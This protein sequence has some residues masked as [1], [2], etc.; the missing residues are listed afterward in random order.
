MSSL[1]FFLLANAIFSMLCGISL[2]G[3]HKT[4][5]KWFGRSK[6]TPFWVLG[7]G[8]VIFSISVFIQVSRPEAVGVFYII[9]QD[10]IWVL[11]SAGILIFKPF[12]ITGKGYKYITLVALI[13]L[14]FGL[15][16]LW[17]LA[18]IDEGHTKGSKQLVY[19]RVV[20]A[21][22]QETWSVVSNV[23][24]YHL[25]APNIDRVEI[26]SGYGEGMVRKCS[27]SAQS[28]TETATLWKEGEAYAFTVDTSAKDY[29]FPFKSLKGT[30]K[31]RS[32]AENQTKIIMIF[33][34]TYSKWIYNLMVHPFL[35]KQF[36]EVCEELLN[37]WENELID[38]S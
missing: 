1:Q 33:D 38:R 21:S 10:F 5:A 20:S 2:I 7:I 22:K 31:V 18:K 27:H 12:N 9:V 23:A 4:I 8:L 6:A 16:Q 29:P 37:N 24:N 14:F 25:V 30:W 19:E 13:V 26:L 34:F 36:S 3:F 32:A 17:G 35:K 15:G 28:W 11:A